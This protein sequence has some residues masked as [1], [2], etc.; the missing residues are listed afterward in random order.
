MSKLFE[1]AIADAKKLKE[2]AELNAKNAIIE[3]ISP[4]I[5]QMIEKEL[6][7]FGSMLFEED[8]MTPVD[9]PSVST[10]DEPPIAV[11]GGKELDVPMVDDDGKVT[12]DFEDLYAKSEKTGDL[13]QVAPSS[14]AS[15]IDT[16]VMSPGPDV[17]A[18][19]V[20][21]TPPT[22]E[23]PGTPPVP[24]ADAS[25]PLA[26]PAPA[27]G[28]ET[29]AAPPA[30]LP[31]PEEAPLTEEEEAAL[32]Y[33][34]FS[35]KL[36]SLKKK[37]DESTGLSEVGKVY[38]RE[39][40]LNLYGMLEKLSETKKIPE[41]IV[42]L[43]E[44]RLEV[45]YKKLKESKMTTIY[46]RSSNS[47]QK[48]QVD[49]AGLKN[50]ASKLMEEADKAKAS[51]GFE[52]EKK[53]AV[54]NAE[55]KTA[56]KAGKHAAAATKPS[57]DTSDKSAPGG[58][59]QMVDAIKPEEKFWNEEIE[60]LE[61]ELAEALGEDLEESAEAVEESHGMDSEGDMMGAKQEKP[62]DEVSE[63]SAEESDETVYE[64]DEKELA[65]AVRSIRKETIKRQMKALK[66][67]YENLAEC[68]DEMGQGFGMDNEAGMPGAPVSAPMSKGPGMADE[69]VVIT[70]S[71]DGGMSVS[72]PSGDEPELAAHGDMGAGDDMDMGDDMDQMDQLDNLD[73][74]GDEHEDVLDLDLELEDEV[75]PQAAP[76]APAAA[77]M[78][79]GKKAPAKKAEPT[80]VE[81]KT[82]KTLKGQLAEQSLLTAK[83]I[84]LNKFLQRENLSR[85]QKQKIVEYLDNARTIEEAKEIYGRIKKV[86]DEAT[87][88]RAVAGSSSK[89]TKSGAATVNE[90]ATSDS[91]M[92]TENRWMQLAGIKKRS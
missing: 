56:D 74:D 53:M 17:A 3:S 36:E 31:P 44:N 60:R 50:M 8:E 73:M 72:D 83:L 34:N 78:H 6:N 5:K 75:A 1:E 7:G 76:A 58:S 24:G 45:L 92:I 67:E 9:S 54:N 38:L 87:N 40:L 47:T 33:E 13:P 29:A 64:V 26:P 32:T 30:P 4:V 27:G 80:V 65:E 62:K 37:L 66:E 11:S 16:A 81:S 68:G 46:N 22:G 82:V 77:P 42:S 12:V 61:A 52:Q 70:V 10:G 71:S 63:G 84:Y 90:S 91:S 86:L 35:M 2:V 55:E 59:D 15:P 43:N 23:V 85:K 51:S 20:E 88:T 89:A 79:E 49:M 19:G 41:K 69:D 48:G 14:P 28:P 21:A 18:S 25:A 39:Q 57:V